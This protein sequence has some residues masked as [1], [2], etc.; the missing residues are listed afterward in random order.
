MNPIKRFKCTIIV[1]YSN[2]IKRL[3]G[4]K[5]VRK[6]LKIIIKLDN[7]GPFQHPSSE[8]LFKIVLAKVKVCLLLVLSFVLYQIS[9]NSLLV[10][11]TPTKR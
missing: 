10:G 4:P 1:D 9:E 8:D 7:L 5:Y 3:E 6:L 2:T 11:P